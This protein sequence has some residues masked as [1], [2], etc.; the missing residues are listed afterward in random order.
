MGLEI[1]IIKRLSGFTLQVNLKCEQGI[2][3]ILG[4]SG[5]GKSMLL[6]CI[7]GLIKPDEGKIIL[8][9]KTLFDSEKKINLSPKDRKVGFLFQNYALFPHMTIA[10]NISFGLGE[11]PKPVR[12]KKVSEL[13]ER[14]DLA[15]MAKRYPT[16]ISG[17]QQQRVALARAV[18]VEPEILLLDEPF[19]ALDNHLRNNMMKEMMAF[20]KE[21][22]GTALLV[23]HNIEEAYRLCSW[24]AVFNTGQVETLNTKNDLFRHPASLETAKITGCKNIAPAIRKSDELVDIPEW[25]IE[26]KSG[27][28]INAETGYAGIRAN[29][30]KLA[31]DK[32]DGL[33]NENVFPVWVAD[34]SEAP[35]RTMLYL[36]IGSKPKGSDDYH[37]LWEISR[38]QRESIR[39]L[40]EPFRIQLEPSN[41]FFVNK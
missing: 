30:I 2:I 13:L 17:G 41:V 29:Y 35:F 10:E 16:Q 25:G 23:T 5:S 11:F 40:S 18:A 20:L 4:A 32:K 27:T 33:N 37:L 24:I 3:G 36:K 14:F 26:L 31:K 6:N 28:H 1:D 12:E 21:Y 15:G 8:N 34:E 9:G 38:E 39:M 7:T 22:K 19:S